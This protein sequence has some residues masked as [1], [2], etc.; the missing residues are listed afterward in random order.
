MLS[1]KSCW[2]VVS[3]HLHIVQF[4]FHPTKQAE[5]YLNIYF[6]EGK[7]DFQTVNLQFPG[8]FYQFRTFQKKFHCRKIKSETSFHLKK[9][10]WFSFYVC[11]AITL[12]VYKEHIVYCMWEWKNA[13]NV[14]CIS[15]AQL[16][17]DWWGQLKLSP[18]V[19]VICWLKDIPS[20]PR[21]T[22]QDRPIKT[23]SWREWPLITSN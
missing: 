17:C 4:E 22:G 2:G 21:S 15:T 23:S 10:F 13:E 7:H 9:S 8:Y 1:K 12:Y 18:P 6:L 11:M 19:F 16:R 14:V 3:A 5:T 20:H